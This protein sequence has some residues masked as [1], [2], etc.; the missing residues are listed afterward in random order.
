MKA[1]M[2]TIG[3]DTY[4]SCKALDILFKEAQDATL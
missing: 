3:A 1:I 2:V 4:K